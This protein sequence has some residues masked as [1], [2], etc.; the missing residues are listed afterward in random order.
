MRSAFRDAR[1]DPEGTVSVL[2]DHLLMKLTHNNHLP[3][4]AMSPAAIGLDL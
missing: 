3:N 1:M 4:L 2:T